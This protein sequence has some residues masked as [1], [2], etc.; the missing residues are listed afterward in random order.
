MYKM[1]N[2]IHN[3]SVLNVLLL[4]LVLI[5]L[6]SELS[7]LFQGGFR[8]S[9]R[10]EKK[11]EQLTRETAKENETLSPAEYASI[12]DANLFHPQRIIPPEKKEEQPL[13]K[14]EFV[15]YG[16]LIFEDSGIAYLED[17]K[18]PR[19][20]AG[21]GTRQIPLREGD[22]LSGFIL[23][24]IAADRVFMRRGEEIITVKIHEN[25]TQKIKDVSKK[26]TQ[27]TKTEPLATAEGL[28]QKIQQKREEDLSTRTATQRSQIRP[29][30]QKVFDMLEYRKQ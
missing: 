18:A 30:D 27:P 25:R 20:T 23:K 5:V 15:L 28:L 12:A 13:P 19:R 6:L 21:R 8:Y 22:T 14:P 11:I 3:I 26:D 29:Q 10:E 4:S 24:Q 9:P 7:P 1:K 2:L 17:L 16:T